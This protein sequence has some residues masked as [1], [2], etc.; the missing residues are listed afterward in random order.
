MIFTKRKNNFILSA[1]LS[2]LF[3]AFIA[4]LKTIDVAPIGPVG[5]EVGFAHLNRAVSNF[6]V[7]DIKVYKV[8][9]ILGYALIAMGAVFALAGVLQVIRR[10]SLLKVDKRIISLGELYV[11]LLGIYAI[12]EKVI[13]NYRPVIMPGEELPEASFP[14]SHTMLAIV[15][16]GSVMMMLKYYISNIHLRRVLQVICLATIF[17]TVSLRLVSGVHWFTDIVGSVLISCALLN[18]FA[19]A[20]K[21]E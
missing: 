7:M 13:I 2:A 8:T 1:V 12:F 3:I 6:F 20:I 9:E 14:S 15:I 21:E 17:T 10:K 11:I 5:T 16:G 4:M 19:G 18:L